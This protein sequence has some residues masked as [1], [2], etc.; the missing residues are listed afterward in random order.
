MARRKSRCK[1]LGTIWE[2]SDALWQ[3]IEPI[4][5]SIARL[6]GSVREQN[7]IAVRISW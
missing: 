2:I 1:P 7:A 5:E 3:R 6:S 4:L